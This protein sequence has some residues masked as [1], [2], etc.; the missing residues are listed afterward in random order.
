MHITSINMAKYYYYVKPLIPRRLQIQ[1]RRWAAIRKRRLC[2]DIW[3]ID[4]NA[5]NAPDGW[6]G[7]P[8]GKRFAL[9]LT[10]D[11]DTFMG[12][13]KCQQLIKLE[14][15]LGFRSSYNFVAA[16]Y[17]VSR[18]LRRHITDRGFEVGVHGLLHN[19]KMYESKS[20]F[21]K[22]AVHINSFLRDWQAA[23][24]RS[25]CMY[26]NLDW[27]QD[28][29]IEYDASTFDTDPFEP[30]PD[31]VGTILPFCVEGTYGRKGYV[32]LP[33]TLPQ[34]FTL[35]VLL[36]EKNIDIWKEKLDWIVECGGMALLNTHPDYMQFS[37]GKSGY[38]GYPVQLYREFLMYVRE[39]YADKYWHVLP[40]EIADFWGRSSVRPE[41]GVNRSSD[42]VMG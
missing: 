24:F 12:H 42:N 39:Q 25:P 26:H 5:G 19:R 6:R 27:L 30:Q 9:V 29:D 37:T 23:G 28:L 36:K 14:T 4:R 8:G 17:P 22:H 10:H 40:K 16:E 1:V 32:E 20:H 7:W 2:T 41:G 35:F 34:D 11:V 38:E 15:E 21:Q 13:E 18:E 3:P 33:Y 31:G